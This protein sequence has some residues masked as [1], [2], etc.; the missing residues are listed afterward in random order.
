MSTLEE[1]TIVIGA[2]TRRL[3]KDMR[4]AENAVTRG[5]LGMQNNATRAGRSSGDS[6]TKAL[7]TSA[8]SG[9][10]RAEQQV[11]RGMNQ[12][13]TAASRA[14]T[15]GGQGFSSAFGQS[16]SRGVHSQV[17]SAARTATNASSR[18]LDRKSVV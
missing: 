15:A 4:H 7:S 18:S 5:F 16:A 3:A 12:W 9:M 2:D 10:R 1:L 11:S 8:Q 14:G 17:Q 13:S 6:Y